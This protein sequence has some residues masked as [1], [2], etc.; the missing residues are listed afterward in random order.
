MSQQLGSIFNGMNPMSPEQ[1]FEQIG[2]TAEEK[3]V[4]FKVSQKIEGFLK[5]NP[6][7]VQQLLMKASQNYGGNM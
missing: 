3:E 5:N 6:V 7:L 4:Y 2:I 1:I